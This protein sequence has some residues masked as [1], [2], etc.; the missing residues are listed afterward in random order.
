MIVSFRAFLLMPLFLSTSL[1]VVSQ[2]PSSD[3]RVDLAIKDSKTE[4][5]S[6]EPILLDLSFI[7]N[8]GKATIDVTPTKPF[9]PI[10][11]VVVSPSEGGFPWLE[12]QVRGK[13]YSPHNAAVQQ[14]EPGTPVVVTLALN[15]LY[16]F[17][18]PGHYK[19]HVMTPR[20]LGAV[21]TSNEVEFDVVS[22]MG[23]EEEA[24]LAANLEKQI[25]EATTL[26]EAERLATEL[27]WL[28]GDAATRAKLSLFL[29]P[30]E[31]YPFGVDM[32]RGLW[33]ARN[34]AMVV[35]ALEKALVDPAQ[36]IGAGS[37]LLETLVALKAR[38]R[39]PYDAEH[40]ETP[41][42]SDQ[43]KA[44][45][46][47]AIAS[48]IGQRT[49]TPRIDA[50]RT[51]FVELA[52]KGAI[53]HPDFAVA[54]EVLVTSFSQVN[55]YNVDWLLG[56]YGQ[57]LEDARLVPALRRLLESSRSQLFIPNRVVALKQLAKLAPHDLPTFLV[58]EACAA[59][60]P[61]MIQTVR[62]LSPAETL[63][64][65]DSCLKE[66]LRIETTSTSKS[67]RR[68]LGSTLA[69]TARFA[70][71]A[72]VPEVRRAYLS[73]DSDWGQ[74]A[75]GAAVVY[76]MRWDPENS[77]SLLSDLLP[78]HD[79]Y[80]GTMLYFLL[81][82]AYPP[83]NGLRQAFRQEIMNAPPRAAGACAFGLSKIGEPEDR[84]FLRD[85]LKR[86]REG[87]AGGFSAQDGRFEGEL[88]G[89]IIT[90]RTWA[91]TNEEAASLRASCVSDEC[92][93]RF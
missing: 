43:I 69:Y 30:K 33:I 48:T 29:K 58:S 51:V 3:V 17:D 38:L 45:Y 88:V 25:R 10:D 79:R 93:R 13:H 26:T 55:E 76:L 35:T 74:D 56:L 59:D 40:P 4:F 24:K 37:N 67:V 6:G 68:N 78:S 9:S 14:L 92:K 60:L 21:L 54:R 16:R 75:I 83:A 41:L 61:V 20:L 57:Y 11:T 12:D 85:Q 42:A 87:R 36:E 80:G 2:V 5:H 73:R 89:A 52:R 64:S 86:L 71:A 44:E 65:V 39:V 77:L 84:D 15:D 81:D 7:A 22:L 18:S 19:V 31:F 66:K 53:E 63:P 1:T 50:A 90:G 46:L 62:D 28:P 23:S 70:S 91:S 47:H 27:D 34:R 72:L 49:G 82:P 8:Q 32:T